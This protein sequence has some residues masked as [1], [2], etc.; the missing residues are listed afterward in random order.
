MHKTILPLLIWGLSTVAGHAQTVS[1]ALDSLT[2]RDG[3]P[4]PSPERVSVRIS[5]SH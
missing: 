3:V 4:S 1:P 2:N 5:L